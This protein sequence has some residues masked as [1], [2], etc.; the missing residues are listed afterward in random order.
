MLEALLIVL[1]V[2]LWLLLRPMREWYIVEWRACS[3]DSLCSTVFQAP[4]AGFD[5]LGLRA[6]NFVVHS[7]TANVAVLRHET[8]AEVIIEQK[9]FENL[10]AAKLH[11]ESLKNL[12]PVGADLPQ[13][14]KLYL[15]RVLARSRH[16]AITL[17]PKDY[18]SKEGQVLLQ[19]PE[20]FWFKPRADVSV[21]SSQVAA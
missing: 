14:R 11:F 8:G 5:K 19:H 1:I 10:E 16:R 6:H 21:L 2:S 7:S 18:S 15:W 20:H 4:A 12:L 17:P 9:V 13:F 3:E